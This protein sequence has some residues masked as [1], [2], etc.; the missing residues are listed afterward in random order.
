M[1]STDPDEFMFHFALK[2][3]EQIAG[4]DAVVLNTFDELEQE[5]LDAMRAMIPP[6]AS[7]H[8][9]GP[10]AFLAEEIVAPGGPTD[11][12]GSNVQPLE[13]RR[14]LLR[15]AP[16]QGAQ[17]GGVRE[18]RQHH[19]DEQR[20]AGG[21]RVGPG[22][23]RPRLPVDHPAGPR[24][25]RRRRAAAG[26]PG[27]HQGPRTPGELVSAGGGAEARGGGRVPDALRVELD[28]GE[29]VRRGAHAVLAFLRGAAD[30]LPV[31]VRGVGRGHGDRP[32]RPA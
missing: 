3:T 29:P 24:Q 27:D 25:R 15:L 13:G 21:I 31:Q 9:I 17:V 19:G 2:V 12:L 8:T 6:S 10:L 4:A 11:A 18:L 16:R 28:H 5:A 23:Q 26:V 7:I 22:Q 30:Q 32:R 20:G 14:L 1:R